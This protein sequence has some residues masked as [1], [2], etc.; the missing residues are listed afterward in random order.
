MLPGRS[1]ARHLSRSRLVRRLRPL[2]IRPRTVRGTAL[3]E[4]A[5]ELPAVIAS[6][7]PGVHQNTADSWK[8]IG[9]QDN[10]CAEEV[11]GLP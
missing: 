1:P 11:T 10:A 5:S 9:G 7:L 3:V 2:G 8:C 4:P 6:R